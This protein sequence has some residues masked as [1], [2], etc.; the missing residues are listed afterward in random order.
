MRVKSN[1]NP[2]PEEIDKNR[3]TTF[4]GKVIAVMSEVVVT[5][6]GQSH[7]VKNN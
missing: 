7:R 3:I 1:S 2:K 5:V 6:G 4:C